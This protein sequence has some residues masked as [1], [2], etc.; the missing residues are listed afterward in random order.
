MLFVL[1]RYATKRPGITEHM[2]VKISPP[3]RAKHLEEPLTEMMKD[4]VLI[5]VTLKKEVIVEEPS[6]A[7]QRVQKETNRIPKVRWMACKQISCDEK[8]L[9]DI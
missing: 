8:V 4:K 2:G 1:H 5:P 6:P 7:P 3:L 9:S